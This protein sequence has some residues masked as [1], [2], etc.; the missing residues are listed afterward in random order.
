MPNFANGMLPF[1]TAAQKIKEEISSKELI[2]M[3]PNQSPFIKSKLEVRH[4]KIHLDLNV[5]IFA[6]LPVWCK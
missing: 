3:I 1:V 2:N 5:N 6:A 4:A